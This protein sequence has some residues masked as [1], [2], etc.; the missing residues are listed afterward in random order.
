[1]A[2]TG[3][4]AVSAGDE[5]RAFFQRRLALFGLSIG[6]GYFAFWLYVL[7]S[8]LIFDGVE[9]LTARSFLWHLAA[10][11]AFL[12]LWLVCRGD[13]V[14]SFRVVS[15][16]ELVCLAAGVFATGMMAL[17]IPLG[18]RPDFVILLALTYVLLLRSIL[19]PCTGR[20]TLMIGGVLGVIIL[21]CVYVGA[22]RIDIASWSVVFPALAGQTPQEAAAYLT[23]EAAVW[24]AITTALAASTSAVFYGLRRRARDAEQLGQYRLE[25]K[26]GEGGMGQ[27]YRASHAFLRRPTAVKLLPTDKA[28]AENLRRF[29]Q[30]V[31]LTASL[32]HPNTITI[33]DYGHTSD[34]V[35]YYAMEYIDGLSLSDL[36]AR[37]GP[38]HP[39]RVVDLIRQ[40]T[41]AL[42][43]AHG[44][45]LVHRDIKP[46][47]IM[48]QLLHDHGMAGDCVKVLDFGLVKQVE[49]NERVELTNEAALLGTPLYM[50]PE[51]IVSPDTIDARADLYALGAVAYYLL[52]GTHVFAGSTVVEVC[53]HHLHSKPDPLSDRLGSPVAR[54][55]EALIL[56]C[57][58][59]DPTDRPQSAMELAESLARCA[60][61]PKWA[62]T[63][64]RQWW[65]E[66]GQARSTPPPADSEEVRTIERR[67][68]PA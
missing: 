53:G 18:R 61:V 42:I 11:V 23:I 47:N 2:D 67:L 63:D 48:V 62:P 17:Y 6:S 55:L 68:D 54:D 66:H 21:S 10:T 7:A 46:G 4:W 27:V 26:L 36:V 19:V 30:E 15:I 1:M 49:Q 38:Q 60:G 16:V 56:R 9:G 8:I 64:A 65:S 3:A 39:G 22:L 14:W 45:G 43:E 37:S 32:R 12:V 5:D 57:L 41:E 24:W 51:A 52:T 20:W 25:E 31:Q 44:V 35:F 34:G 59:K 50:A 29:E 40:A 58:A 13:K 33:F 28:G